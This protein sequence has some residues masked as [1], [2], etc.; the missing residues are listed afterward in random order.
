MIMI[1]TQRSVRTTCPYCGVGCQIDL[2][3]KDERIYRVDAPFDVAPN[4][5]RLCAKGRFGVDFVHHPSRLTQPLIRKD[6]GKLP[7]QA[8][9]LDG[10]REATW[11]EALDLSTRHIAEI[12]EQHGGDA[13]GTFCSAKAT[14]EDNYVFQK[15]VRAVLGTNNIDHCARLCHAASVTGL[16]IAIGS[17]AMSNSIAEMK[18]LEVF[19]ITGSN[20]SETHPVISTFMREAVVK[21]GARLIVIDP[22]Q[23]EMTQFATYW[24]RNAPGSDVAVFQAIAHTIVK[25][26]LYNREFIHAR[27]DDFEPYAQSLESFTPEWAEAI[28]GVPADL[29]RQ[30]ARLYAGAQNA[31]IYWGMGIS[32]SVHGTDNA[33]S[34]A[35]LAL[36]TGNLG[37]PG[38]GL[39]TLRGQN[40]VQGCSD[41]GGL[42]NVF[43]GYQDVSDDE[44]RAKFEAAWNTTLPPVPGLSTM[45]MVDAAERGAIHAYFV[46]GENPMMSE[47]DLRHARHVMEQ[48]DFVLVQDIFMNETS[49]YADVILP[50][51]SFAERDGTFTNSD[52]RVQLVRKALNAPGKARP[53]WEVLC[54]L[55]IRVEARFEREQSAG[56]SYVSSSQIWDE[57]AS[58]TPP[59][60]GINHARIQR[61]SGV[62]WPCPTPDHPGTPTL[63]AD[64]FP[65]GKGRLTP[66]SFEPGAELPDEEFPYVLSTGRV[67]YHWHGG[68]MTR[69]SKLD[70]IYPEPTVEIHPD[71]AQGLGITTGEWIRVR[72]R[73]GQ[74]EVKA[75]VTQRSPQGLVF[76]PFHFAEAAA[77]ELTIDAR[78]PLAKIPDYKVCAIA[79]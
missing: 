17:S 72:S 74:I 4:Y 57:M 23:I 67:L 54:D 10:F 5:G 33:L 37:R 20:T 30:T 7:R 2:Q 64:D 46:M 60:Q 49:E 44:I 42:P 50:A 68:T 39:N 1:E 56:F 59:F 11:E 61:E 47:P 51:A 79:L 76:I 24:L 78:D 12:V 9:G 75:L 32:Q 36:L 16:Q 14:N 31:A 21:N 45:E 27:V 3:L 6:L 35:N 22:R 15:F 26:E 71:D 40:N 52:R 25:E 66:L 19:I 43:P 48:L 69:R 62:H 13:I 8:I 29:I 28:S 55:A 73:R 63:F 41:S 77:N 65:S 58:L 34:L 70:D 18:D 53:D 38:T